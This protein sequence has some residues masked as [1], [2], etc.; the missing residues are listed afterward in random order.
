LTL[1]RYQELALAAF[2]RDRNTTPPTRHHT[3]V[4]APPGSGKTVMGLEMARRL[5]A[6]AVVLC[7]TAA[8]QGQWAARAAD[9]ELHVLTYQALCRTDDPDGALRAAAEARLGVGGG[10]FPSQRRDREVARAVAQIKVEI[11]RGGDARGLLSATAVERVDALRDAGVRTVILDECHH[12]VSLWGYLIKAVLT[13][14][15]PDVHVIG[16][17]ATAPDDMTAD[18]AELYQELLGPVDFHTPTPAV[19]REG[20][21]APFQELALFTTPLDSELE[22]LGA[23]HERFRELL[24]RLMEVDGE[25][26]F[27]VWVSNRLRYRG[28]GDA[29][30]PFGELLRRQPALARAGLRY[31]ASA[32]L[33]LPPGAPRG[34]GFREAPTIDDWIVLLSDY[35][36][37]CLRAHEG[38]GE[39]LDELAVG[40]ADLG[41]TLTRTGIRPGRTDIDRVLVNSAAKQILACEALAVEHETRGDALRAVVLCDSE[42]PP[43]QP[44]GSAL[45]PGGGGR[46]LL[47]TIAADLRLAPLRPLL[48]TG[49]DPREEVGRATEALRTGATQ[50][51]IATRALLGE[52]WDAPFVNVL[53][54]ATSVAAS[55]STR[56]M[57][58][59]T[60]R[61]DPAD[62]GK[63]ASNWDLVCVAPA[64]E[65]GTA[66]YERFVR[67]H[68]HLHAP[69]ED[70]SIESGVSHVHPELSPFAPPPAAEFSEL[71]A[72]ARERAA[73]P[74]AARARWRIGEPYRA[75]ELPALLVRRRRGPAMR[76]EEAAIAVGELRPAGKPRWWLPPATRRRRFP[77]VLPL[78]RV[79]RAVADSYL[80][81][82]EITPAAAA[83]LA[84]QP[85]AG[86]YVRCLL[87]DG[88]PEE[89]GRFA[90]ALAEA[91]E[92][93]IAQRYVIARPLGAVP[94]GRAWHPVPSDLARN[95]TR[96][97]AYAAAFA[98]WL[99]P[100][101]LR[102]TLADAT[103]LAAAAGAG[104]WEAQTRRL[105]V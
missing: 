70:G 88:S 46:G 38:T 26:S 77:A 57:R 18:E 65:R 15:G 96:A 104:D 90:S 97:D 80:A 73:D 63:V 56:Q 41:F 98:R 59:R 101:E 7:P 42:R 22:W 3:Y 13:E 48:V 60:L 34:E 105:W 68:Q 84:W 1:R 39:R 2:E 71:N 82:G 79:A 9:L 69:C 99:G 87:A 14:L 85:R 95:R 52:G 32:G 27:P 102:Y 66:D 16:L 20:F 6:P 5:G 61:L 50:C 30:I 93:A 36:I 21:L 49:A 83:S 81:L 78:Q 53:I 86:G 55:I 100:G 45:T 72:L 91:V 44:E 67:R 62:P 94:Y 64:L 51:L 47:E 35:A 11:A 17:T 103:G 75:E 58:G 92:P 8:I 29:E 4:V 54:D 37:R 28:E 10:E 89:N 25:L 23:R 74:A 12:V 19:V 33:P 76:G 43:K 40:L 31:L 24:D